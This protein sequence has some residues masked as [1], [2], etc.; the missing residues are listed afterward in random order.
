MDKAEKITMPYLKII[1]VPDNRVINIDEP[2]FGTLVFVLFDEDGNEITKTEIH[3][4]DGENVFITVPKSWIG[5][6]VLVKYGRK[7]SAV[8][9]SENVF[10]IDYAPKD[11]LYSI[12]YEEK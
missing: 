1:K 10:K 8:K 2:V 5:K 12:Y 3:D 9:L 4:Y 7:V 11:K 6:Q